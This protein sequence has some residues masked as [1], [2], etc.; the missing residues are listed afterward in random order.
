MSKFSVITTNLLARLRDK[1]PDRKV[2]LAPADAFF[3]RKVDLPENLSWEEQ[4][5]FV[6]LALEGSAPFPMEQ[7]AWGFLFAP[8]SAHAFVYATPKSRLKR[9]DF[10][11]SD[12]YLQLFPGFISLNGDAFDQ[13]TVRFIVWNGVLSALRFAAHN[14]VP[15]AVTSRKV[16]GGLLTDDVLLAARDR[17]AAS[18]QES[19]GVAEDGLWLGQAVEILP[20]DVPRF[21]HRHLISSGSPQPLRDHALQL[22]EQALWAA[23][24]RDAAYAARES[25][26]RRRSRVVWTSLRAA[27]WTAVA[28]LFLQLGTLALAGFNMLRENR[29]AELSPLAERVEN[30]LTLAQRL[31]QSTEEDLKPFLLLE[32]IN[33]LRPDSIFYD[34]V[35][36]Q[37]FNEL[38][39]EGQS[40]EGVTPVNAFA[41]SIE[42]LDFVA[43][44]VNN[45]QTRSNQ[46]SFEFIT[47]FASLPPEPEGGFTIPEDEEDEE[48]AEEDADASSDESDDEDPETEAP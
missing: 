33:P 4:V 36:S 43:A 37:A 35:R 18:L 9:L 3:T 48:D 41:E 17:L 31:T 45:S 6:E 27:V 44:V 25:A 19:D 26:V 12:K 40:T 32:S 34:R 20:G 15:V 22:S 23:D 46:T 1:L 7:M 2:G 8:G 21:R 39:I 28:L 42:Q 13:D 29:I 38:R 16:P 14:P 5:T 47:T 24:L 10:E 30:K 11:L